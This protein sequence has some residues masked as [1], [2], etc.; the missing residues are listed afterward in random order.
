MASA[1]RR[2]WAPSCRSRSIRRRSA[3]AVSVTVSRPDSSSAMRR[4]SSSE[5]ESS[6]RT[7]ARST[8]VSQRASHGSSGQPTKSAQSTMAKPASVQGSRTTKNSAV[9][10]PTGSFSRDHSQGRKPAPRL[11]GS[12]LGSSIRSR[13]SQRARA[14]SQAPRRRQPTRPRASSGSPTTVID[15]STPT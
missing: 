8:L 5:G 13:S 9:R 6:D 3:L 10:Q 7:S 2:A 11:P 1:T 15:V 12:R 14:R 4:S